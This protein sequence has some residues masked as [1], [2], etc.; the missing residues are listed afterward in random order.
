MTP[1]EKKEL[2]I[3]TAKRFIGKPYIWGGDDPVKGF[4]CSGYVIEILKSVGLLPRKGDWTAN[5]LM[6]LFENCETIEPGAGC[7]VFWGRTPN[8]RN[9]VHVEF[10]L[11]DELAIGASGGGSRTKS[12][13]DAIRQNAYVKIRPFKSR[14]NIIFFADPFRSTLMQRNSDETN[15]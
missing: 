12:E 14:A 5:G 4:D 3:E 6:N 8:D 15:R 2:A 7:L 9:A 13:A 1:E 11:S 10:C